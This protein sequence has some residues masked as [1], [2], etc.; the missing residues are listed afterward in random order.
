MP[1]SQTHSWMIISV[2][3]TEQWTNNRSTFCWALFELLW[4]DQCRQTNESRTVT[5]TRSTAVPAT[6]V[7]T[8]IV[9]WVCKVRGV[10]NQQ[11]PYPSERWKYSISLARTKSERYR[12]RPLRHTCTTLFVH[13]RICPYPIM[14]HHDP[15]CPIMPPWVAYSSSMVLDTCPP[16]VYHQANR[17]IQD[18]VRGDSRANRTRMI[19]HFT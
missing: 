15:S 1:D 5:T 4:Y 13:P 19:I 8:Y 6:R 11:L 12:L 18:R 10:L 7:C 17:V 3:W 16:M 2:I 9:V 14:R